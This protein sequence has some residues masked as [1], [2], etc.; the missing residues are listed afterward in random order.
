MGTCGRPGG[1]L[2]LMRG[3]RL[4]TDGPFPP[5]GGGYA[6]GQAR[7]LRVGNTK[8]REIKSRSPVP[9]WGGPLD[10]P[11]FQKC[12]FFPGKGDLG[13]PGDQK[14]QLRGESETKTKTSPSDNQRITLRQE[15]GPN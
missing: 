2:L 15:M 4:L 3:D 13:D 6:G 14:L 1:V 7:N 10:G 8:G 11:S 5:M 9:S 12:P